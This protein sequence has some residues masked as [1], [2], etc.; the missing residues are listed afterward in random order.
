M[1]RTFYKILIVGLALV[2]LAV[3]ASMARDIALIF[4]SDRA[5]FSRDMSADILY[6]VYLIGRFLLALCALYWLPKI[7]KRIIPEVGAL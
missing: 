4:E 6:I 7:L 3:A 1:D 5:G 2:T